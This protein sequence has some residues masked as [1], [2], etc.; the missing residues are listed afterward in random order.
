MVCAN[1][2]RNAHI[3]YGLRE[4]AKKTFYLIAVPLRPYNPRP[5]HLG[6]IRPQEKFFFKFC[7]WSNH[8]GPGT[9][10]DLSDSKKIVTGK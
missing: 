4:A 8:Q 2:Q 6:G 10:P 1:R 7:K 3:P 9:P 5:P